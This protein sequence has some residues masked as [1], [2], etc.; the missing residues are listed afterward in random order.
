MLKKVSVILCFVVTLTNIV[1]AQNTSRP[2]IWVKQNEKQT[3]L[4]NI[5]TNAWLKEY[6]TSFVKRVQIDIDSFQQNPKQYLSGLPFNMSAQ[7]A[8]QIPP[9]ITVLNADKD[10]TTKRNRYQHY[11]KTAID[12]GIIY[13]L[14]NDEKYAKFSTTVFY[15]FLKSMLQLKPS[16]TSFN[17]GLIYQDDHLRES[18]EIGAQFP[19]IYD[20]IYNYISKGG[21]AYN[22]ITDTYDDVS[23]S[24]SETI[25]KTYVH[26]ALGRGIVNCNWPV[27]ESSSLVSNTLALNSESERNKYLYYYLEKDTTHQDA[28]PKVASVFKKDI[29]WPESLNYSTHVAELSTY[30]M[31][32]LTKINPSLHLGKKYPEVLRALTLPYYLTYPNN[33]QKILFG[34]GGRSYHHPIISYELG[35]FLG[36]LENESSMVNEFGS[37]LNTAIADSSYKRAHLAPRSYVAHPYFEEPLKLLWFC[38]E[39]KGEVKVYPQPTTLDLPFAGILLQRNLSKTGNAKDGLMAFVG[40]GSFV[41]GHASGMNME[42]YGQGHVLGTKAGKGAYGTEIHEN[43]YRLFAGH[44]TVVVN[45]ASRGEGGWVNLAINTVTKVA[46]EPAA[47]KKPV[48]ENYSFTTSGFLDDK[49]DAAEAKQERTVG[50][51]RTSPTTGYYIDVYRSSSSLPNQYH[52]YIY[53]NVG[54]SLV[55]NS[56][57]KDFTL[58]PDVDRYK[59]SKNN[60]WKS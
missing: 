60:E 8:G 45:G 15:T 12:C 21:K 22:F 2:M 55:F 4:K 24:E 44:N 37:L 6:Y 11:L 20:F 27:L 56:N 34:D 50:I 33:V 52:D 40:G 47:Y 28:L 5:E 35:Y 17:G 3:I 51:I 53:H 46:M 32:L 1:K 48:S 29:N 31:A 18:R 57:D 14:T 16:E 19:I 38:P 25:F 43:Y 36:S 10:A 54:D 7:K 26:L 9:F 30:L 23:I 39:I 59:L 49:G 13:Y 41:H 58:K 42:L